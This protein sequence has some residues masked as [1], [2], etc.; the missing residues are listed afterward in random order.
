MTIFVDFAAAV[1]LD[2]AAS[3]HFEANALTFGQYRAFINNRYPEHAAALEEARAFCCLRPSRSV[4]LLIASVR[5]VVSS[6][7]T[8]GRW[9]ALPIDHLRHAATRQRVNASSASRISG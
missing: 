7:A 2:L 1:G 3:S 5:E 9:G 8:D 6:A 4:K